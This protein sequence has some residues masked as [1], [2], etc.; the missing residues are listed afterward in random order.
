[1]EPTSRL[2]PTHLDSVPEATSNLIADLVSAASTL[3]Q[4]LAP[5]TA[6]S[7]ANVVR[8]MNCYY[9]NLIEGHNTR[10]KEI[11]QALQRDLAAEPEKRSLQLEAMAHIR[12]QE[13]IDN[14]HAGG[15][16]PEPASVDFIRNLHRDFYESATP[17]M[18]RVGHLQMEPGEMRSRTGEDSAVGLH[19]PPS[20]DRV[21]AFMTY[22]EERYRFAGKGQASRLL[23]MAIAHHRLNYIHPFLDG[24]GRVS[25]L[26]SHAMGLHAGIGARGLWSISRGL[27]RGLSDR[28][29]YRRMMNHADSPRQGDLDGRGNLSR[30]ATVEFIDWFLSV[31][32]DQI[33]FMSVLFDLGNLARRY[34]IY[35]S[36]QTKLRPEA[37]LVVKDI[38]KRGYLARGEVARVTGMPERSARVVTQGLLAQGLVGS[39]TPKSELF[40]RFRHDAIPVL[41]PDLYN[42]QATS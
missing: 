5:E 18:L 22:F 2:E 33:R 38:L 26:M 10:L 21:A 9:S 8:V 28:G 17:E 36:G 42:A 15:T 39:N 34:D 3:G 27:A 23:Y 40:L 35:I 24:N 4:S 14:A 12:V 37:A 19:Q 29:E 41:F 30:K 20:S 13:R 7:L 31:A 11:E 25:R 6:D 16:L 32:I 1:M